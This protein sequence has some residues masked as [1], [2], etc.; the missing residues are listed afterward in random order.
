MVTPFLRTLLAAWLSLPL[1]AAAARGAGAPA[2]AD[3]PEFHGPR[4]DN[5]SPETG[6][7]RKWPEG[8]P[9]LLWTASGLGAGFST[10]AIAGDT[11][12]TAGKV[13]D[14]TYV[15]A[16]DLDGELRWKAL[17][18]GAWEAP[19]RARWARNQDGSR[20]TPT[21]VGDRAFHMN[22]LGR[23]A[24]FD[25]R[26]GRELWALDLVKRFEAD[27]PRWGY[28]E[29]V[30]VADGRLFCYPGGRKGYMVALKPE[31]GS[32][33]WAN[34]AIG[35]PPSY[36]SAVLV[37]F[38]GERQ[39]ITMTAKGVIGVRPRDGVLLWRYPHANR[40]GINVATP[41]FADG[42][43]YVST[44][45]GAG[46]VMVA[47]RQDE[48]RVAAE[49]GWFHKAPDNHHGGIVL[50][51][52]HLYGSGDHQ[53]GWW[54]LALATGEVKHTHRGV[55]KGSVSYADGMLYCLGERGEMALV[56]ATPQAHRIVSRFTAPRGGDGL[57]WGHPVI[58]RGRLYVRHA[59]RLF[60]Y[61]V[62]AE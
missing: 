61:D 20:A 51:D 60:C 53:R 13:K 2:G 34:T 23:L 46:G 47:L 35:E 36:S 49:K 22:C 3:W 50:V 26:T 14:R 31:D 48:G 58:R 11:L 57:H 30:L 28:A 40:R 29:S 8:G 43:V 10:V 17:N 44:G 7:L 16:L 19:R 1:T 5:R 45:Y 56:E 9:K 38:A 18:G 39:L 41:I 24:A 27:P 6:L 42:R 62:R 33:A 52:G 32:V 15:F 59:D 25:A 37:A 12:Y 55:G 4:R 21:V 54:C